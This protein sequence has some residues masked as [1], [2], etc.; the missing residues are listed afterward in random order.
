[1]PLESSR[2]AAPDAIQVAD[3]FHCG[4]TCD[5]VEKTVISC[6]SDLRELAPAPDDPGEAAGTG[7]GIPAQPGQ[8]GVVGEQPFA[9]AAG[10]DRADHQGELVQEP[11]LDQRP[12]Q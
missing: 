6:C 7:A 8:R 9:A 5:A 12:D 4:R 10:D 1:M 3:R 11:L 2:E